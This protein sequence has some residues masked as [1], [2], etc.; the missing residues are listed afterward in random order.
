M[1]IAGDQISISGPESR[2]DSEKRG[3]PGAPE[4]GKDGPPRRPVIDLTALDIRMEDANQIRLAELRQKKRMEKIAIEENKVKRLRAYIDC[5]HGMN[6]ENTEGCKKGQDDLLALL[7]NLANSDTNEVPSPE[8]VLRSARAQE[9][10]NVSS[11]SS[12]TGKATLPFFN[13]YFNYF[14]AV[15]NC[16]VDETTLFLPRCC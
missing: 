15:P 8:V 4:A 1:A 3:G 9:P 12:S 10:V 14:I 5:C 13:I 7:Y 2:R 16:Q 11:S 6:Q